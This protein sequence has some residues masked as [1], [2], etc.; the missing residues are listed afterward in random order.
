LPVDAAER[1][2]NLQKA[3]RRWYPSLHAERQLMRHDT[4]E[5]RPG[6]GKHWSI[7]AKVGERRVD[8]TT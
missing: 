7:H 8:T 3:E 5:I 2:G 4:V 1:L 6:Y